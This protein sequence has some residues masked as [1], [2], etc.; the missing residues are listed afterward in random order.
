M[1]AGREGGSCS[2]AGSPLHPR[3]HSLSRSGVTDGARAE[4]GPAAAQ[5]SGRGRQVS[6]RGRRLGGRRGRNPQETL[7]G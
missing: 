7:A 2:P 6:E 4:G 1:R 3:A 5:R